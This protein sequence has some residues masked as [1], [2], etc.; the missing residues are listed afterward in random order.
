MSL[1]V[2]GYVKWW[3]STKGY[4]FL[5]TGDG[6]EVFLH[7]SM[8]ASVEPHELEWREG[9]EFDL[10]ELPEGGLMAVNVRSIGM[11]AGA[12]MYKEEL[13]RLDKDRKERVRVAKQ[14]PK[15]RVIVDVNILVSGAMGQRFFY[16]RKY[17]P[18]G[19]A[20]LEWAED[21]SKEAL[22][23][24]RFGDLEVIVTQELLDEWQRVREYPKFG[25]QLIGPEFPGGYVDRLLAEATV[26][27]VDREITICRDPKDNYLLAAADASDAD[28]LITQDSDL[29]ALKNFGRTKIVTADVFFGRHPDIEGAIGWNWRL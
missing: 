23:L 13:A 17:G 21:A 12:A 19:S 27:T 18:G 28:Y 24:Q 2:R 4:G 1:V 14:K 5:R 25:Q 16:R 8:M 20:E 3:N 29:L 11:E 10:T 26:Y 22:L 9:V 6:I 15:P 7:R